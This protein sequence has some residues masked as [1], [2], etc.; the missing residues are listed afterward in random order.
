MV[1]IWAMER[2]IFYDACFNRMLGFGRGDRLEP[3]WGNLRIS[4]AALQN[5]Q[6]AE[7]PVP[8]NPAQAANKPKPTY[9]NDLNRSKFCG[10]PNPS[11][12]FG[13]P[14]NADIL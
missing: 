12:P 9:C 4:G 2:G 3:V 6:G 5:P 1:A 8:S 10:I 13:S 7:K 14:C 11:S